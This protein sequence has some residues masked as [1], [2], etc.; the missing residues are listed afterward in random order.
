MSG[1]QSDAG[2]TERQQREIE[3]HREYAAKQAAER[4]RPVNFD[5]VEP[6]PRRPTNA[7]WSTYDL[8]L[9]HDWKGKRALAPGCGFGED[10]ARLARLGAEVHAFDISPEIVDIARA[11]NDGF[12]YGVADYRVAACENLPYADNFFDL[13]FVVDILH[14]VDIPRSVAEFKRVLKPGGRIIGDELYTHSFVQRRIR[15]STIVDKGLYPLMKKFIYGG[16]EPY[17]TA[18]EHKIDEHEFS[19]V[20]A[21]CDPFHARWYNAMVGRIAPDRYPALSSLDRAI[22]GALGARGRYL[23]GRVVFEG[24]VAKR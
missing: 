7:F 10:A 3:Y 9:A 21:A 5:V 15:E 23:A 2:L 18:D 13:V 16:K 22:M 24:V 8:L 20:E 4:A 17:I 12:G 6:G 1:A 19:H 14:H 11:R